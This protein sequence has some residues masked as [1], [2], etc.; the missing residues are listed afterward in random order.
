MLLDNQKIIDTCESLQLEGDALVARH[1]KDCKQASTS[2]VEESQKRQMLFDAEVTNF[3][4]CVISFGL[5]KL[6]SSIR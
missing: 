3:I 2:V 1:G 6:L 5:M 4:I